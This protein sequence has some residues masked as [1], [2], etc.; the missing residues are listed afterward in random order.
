MT[1]AA[2]WPHL[3]LETPQYTLQTQSSGRK[4][5]YYYIM[6]NCMCVSGRERCGGVE[7]ACS[8]KDG[9]EEVRKRGVKRRGAG[10]D[11]GVVE[12]RYGWSSC[13][14]QLHV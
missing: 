4:R 3:E 9:V 11:K 12:P 14:S 7:A 8:E 13:A 6:F 1:T 5:Q 2:E 10:R